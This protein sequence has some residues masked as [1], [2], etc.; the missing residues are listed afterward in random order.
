MNELLMSLTPGMRVLDLGAR[1]GSFAADRCPGV[2]VVRLDLDEFHGSAGG[3][4]VQG[5]AGL[6]PFPSGAFDVVIAN[7][8][9]EHIVGLQA[10]LQEI[11]R[12]IRPAGSLFV[13]VP[14]SSTW[15]DR[16]YRWVYHGGGH[17]NPFASLAELVEQIQSGSGLPATGHRLLHT[18]FGF[19]ERRHFKPRPRR[20]M[21]L[22]GNGSYTVVAML[23]YLAR[24]L[25]RGF[26]TRFS[27]YGWAVSFGQIR[28]DSK[29]WSNVCVQCGGAHPCEELHPRWLRRYDCPEC[30]SW[31]LYTPDR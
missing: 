18:S 17:V 30:G 4:A 10:A 23:G 20:R 13:A 9:L 2:L 14:D 19:L 15:S 8:S 16:I 29:A 22:F 3:H 5:D 6:L 7:H 21:W 11:G 28:I 1:S 12:V 25:D 27:I 26:G 31:N 24:L